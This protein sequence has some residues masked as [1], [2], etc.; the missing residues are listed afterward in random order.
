MV[1]SKT[2]PSPVLAHWGEY[3]QNSNIRQTLVGDKIVDLSDVTGFNGICKDNCGMR[4][5]TFKFWYLV[6][7]VL[8]VWR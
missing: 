2:I 5:E 1:Q 4:P 6:R 8:E 3:R 7:L